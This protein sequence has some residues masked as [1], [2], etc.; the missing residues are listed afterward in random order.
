MYA[1]AYQLCLV[2]IFT[3]RSHRHDFHFDR[4]LSRFFLLP[5]F[6]SMKNI[7]NWKKSRQKPTTIHVVM[8]MCGTKVYFFN[9][10]DFFLCWTQNPPATET[11]HKSGNDKKG[12]QNKHFIII[13]FHCSILWFRYCVRVAHEAK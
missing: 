7:F 6:A 12:C 5:L 8:V 3:N 10:K 4:I 11:G 9:S 13:L 1:R 2:C